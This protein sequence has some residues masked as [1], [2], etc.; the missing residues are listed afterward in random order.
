M[1]ISGL[2]RSRVATFNDNANP[3]RR[4]PLVHKSTP[5]I[6]DGTFRR[7]NYCRF[8]CCSNTKQMRQYKVTG[9]CLLPGYISTCVADW[10]VAVRSDGLNLELTINL[11]MHN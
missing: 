1:D 8:S 7:I 9:S 2:D 4:N 3:Q 10:N 5:I 6:E 11:T